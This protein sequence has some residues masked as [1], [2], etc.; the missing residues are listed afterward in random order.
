MKNLTLAIVLV[1]GIAAGVTTY[2]YTM[3]ADENP[4]KT[5]AATV[6][7]GAVVTALAMYFWPSRPKMSRE[8]FVLDPPAAPVIPPPQTVP[9]P[10]A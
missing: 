4:Q 5:F 8:P 7:I 1:L 6:L 9:M 10:T 2:R 3:E